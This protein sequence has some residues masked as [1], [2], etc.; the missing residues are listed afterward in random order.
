M[1]APP[2]ANLTTLAPEPLLRPAPVL[3]R[4][5]SDP[6][7]PSRFWMVATAALLAPL[8]HPVLRTVVGVPSHLLWFSLVLP[9]S[10]VTYRYGGR[11]GIGLALG[12]LALVG[13]GEQLFGSGY[14]TAA[15]PATV[16]ALIVAVGFT[17]LLVGRFA[18]RVRD[19]QLRRLAAEAG[20]RKRSSW[21]PSGGLRV[22]SGTT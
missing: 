3:L 8:L 21:K 12:S 4:A 2:I 10:M 6:D 9:V 11:Q 15:D 13:A 14:G 18:I 20:R 1:H 17:Q 22:A 16:L 7:S 19:E 5:W